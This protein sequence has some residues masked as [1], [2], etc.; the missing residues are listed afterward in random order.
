MNTRVLDRRRAIVTGA[1]RGL[2]RAFAIGLAES[3]ADVAV[4]DVEPAVEALPPVLEGHGVR[5]LAQV[6]DVSKPEDVHAFV[7]RAAR[8]LGGLDLVVSNA[9]V[10]R[11]TSPVTDSWEQAVDDFR[12][13]VDVNLGGTF[14][15]GRAAIPHLIQRGGDIVNITTDHIHTCGYPI[16]VDH[17]D[18]GACDWAT[19]RRPPIG[20]QGYDLYD[21][22][23][24][25]IK[26]LTLVWARS[27][28]AHGIR[29]NSLGMGPTNAPMYRSHIGEAT[30]PPTMMAPEQ[31]AAVLVELI[32]EGPGGRTGDS[33]ELWAG[34][35][36][37]LPPVGLD[38][39]LAR[40][41]KPPR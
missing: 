22:S 37:V 24:W 7:Q 38:G 39:S 17:A 18:A 2:G 23:K 40:N 20:G 35:P 12:S 3:G 36:C 27:L 25:G 31:I 29:V 30:P 33:V 5:A 10:L 21:A 19:V 11:L 26:G 16:E 32:A 28:A 1:A 15:V 13:M 14:L 34:H 4:C 6:A 8:E 41:V 9:G